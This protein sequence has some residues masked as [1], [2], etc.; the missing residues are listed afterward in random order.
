[1]TK[2]SSFNNYSEYLSDSLA[3]TIECLKTAKSG[4]DFTLSKNLHKQIH[5]KLTNTP[6]KSDFPLVKLAARFNLNDL[7]LHT[8]MVALLYS[9]QPN[10]CREFS[11]IGEYYMV[12]SVAHCVNS[13]PYDCH[14]NFY[15]SLSAQFLKSFFKEPTNNIVSLFEYPVI[16][17][18]EVKDFISENTVFS[19]KLM[20]I[21][22]AENTPNKN[23]FNLPSNTL[24]NVFGTKGSGRLHFLKHNLFANKDILFFNVSEFLTLSEAKKIRTASQTAFIAQLYDAAVCFN[25]EQIECDKLSAINPVVK[26]LSKHSIPVT[27][28]SDSRI[29]V[30]TLPIPLIYHEIKKPSLENRVKLWEEFSKDYT[31]AKNVDFS[32]LAVQF[33]FTAGKIKNTLKKASFNST[34]PLNMAEISKACLPSKAQLNRIGADVLS[35]H[36]EWDDL[37][38]PQEQKATLRHACNFI[39]HGYK[40]YHDW[41]FS[42]KLPY[43]KNLSILM[44]GP[45]GTGKTMAAQ[46]IA[47]DLGLSLIELNPSRIVSKYIGE[48]EKNLNLIFDEA[49]NCGAALFI[50]EMDSLF[51][52]RSQVNDSHDK[53]ANMETSFLLQKIESFNGV[54]LLATNLLS[55]IDEA[56]IRRIK[57]IV[58]FPLPDSENRK[59]LWQ[60][61]LGSLNCPKKEIDLDFLAN[62]FALSG[63]SIKNIVL[64]S[65]FLS[66]E[67]NEI[68]SM[69]HILLSLNSEM[70]K[71]G[72]ILIPSDFG[73]YSNLINE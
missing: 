2:Q 34:E 7:Q 32:Q 11:A 21:L 6:N 29:I 69:H 55:N 52:K 73:K 70:V 68:L 49:Q 48:T 9:L 18:D 42:N 46:V 50:D 71:Q 65:A 8:I 64:K 12:S 16:L 61:M 26:Q 30:S 38:L 27:I 57:F 44:E 19:N 17:Q 66:A 23:N 13:F 1:M 20:R 63:G 14:D 15:I 62:Q 39:H 43:G 10:L 56:F 40:V 35:S 5:L 60:S 24:L 51:G 4:G 31:C 3:L 45:P 72:K 54:L 22:P 25:A 33:D 47:N 67:L 36:F 58:H 53:Y 28:I 41:G 37:I 59:K